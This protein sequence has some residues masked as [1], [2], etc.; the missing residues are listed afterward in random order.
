ME[1]ETIGIM[2]AR[3]RSL[4]RILGWE[5]GDQSECCGLTNSQRTVILE[6]GT[7]GRTSL[8]DL[9]QGLGLD[10]STL[11]RTINGLVNIGLVRREITPE[12]RRYVALTLTPQGS[13]TCRR[14][15]KLVDDYFREALGSIPAAKHK[16][17]VEGLSLLAD[18][19]ERMCKQ[20]QA[21]QPDTPQDPKETENVR[22]KNPKR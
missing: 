2:K 15:E 14:I 3:L 16:T 1:A 10:A 5:F 13:E 21:C 19:L 8:V 12:D 17:V 22:D 7:K 11:S 18:T 20:G 9:A 4:E 6:V